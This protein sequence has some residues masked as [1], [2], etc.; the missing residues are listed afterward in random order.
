MRLFIYQNDSHL[1]PDA[2][3]T[4]TG[5]GWYK[6]GDVERLVE[7]LDEALAAGSESDDW[8]HELEHLRG[9][10]TAAEEN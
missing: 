3:K 10:L 6:D 4:Q 9:L 7:A 1:E 2:A 5:Y 8:P